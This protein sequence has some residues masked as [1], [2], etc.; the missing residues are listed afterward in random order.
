MNHY[1]SVQLLYSS[2]LLRGG[3]SNQ[4]LPGS[5]NTPADNI[6]SF[7]NY[8][9]NGSVNAQLNLTR[10]FDIKAFT[11][12]YAPYITAGMGRMLSDLRRESFD[13][14]ERTLN[15]FDF[16]IYHIGLLNRFRINNN[17]DFLFSAMYFGSQ[18]AYLDYVFDAGKY[19]RYL[20]FNAGIT[21]KIG[22]NSRDLADWAEKRKPRVRQQR[23][24]D[25]EQVDGPVAKS[26]N[27]DDETDENKIAESKSE[28]SENKT[29]ANQQEIAKGKSTDVPIE[30]EKNNE[31]IKQTD[32]DEASQ[33]KKKSSNYA[34]APNAKNQ[35]QA[36]PQLQ[37]KPAN[38][39]KQPAPTVNES[40]SQ[41]P[42]TSS[43][44]IKPSTTPNIVP[45]ENTLV[46]NESST[47]K[48]TDSKSA[49]AS[50]LSSELPNDVSLPIK[51]YN[52]I[53][54]SFRNTNY[55]RTFAEKMRKQGHDVHLIKFTAQHEY[56]RICILTTDDRS[57]A[58]KVLQSA[59]IKINPETWLF[60]K[61]D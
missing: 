37:N 38:I 17:F 34:D 25:K 8:Y 16:Y 51:K 5:N 27:N 43:T 30:P 56:T 29:K 22:G 3:N 26:K 36:N 33:E 9:N 42:S 21:Y 35:A 14:S 12:R 28:S 24:N 61:P 47:K 20:S 49:N 2:G 31:P 13:G 6:K 4:P 18:A 58:I 10:A 57:E 59:R 48:I 11:N 50:T 44:N 41:Q 7:T 40:S 60:V 19:D 54:N 52:V 39:K 45:N 53:V 23:I 55:A 32:A 15:D 1:L 46:A